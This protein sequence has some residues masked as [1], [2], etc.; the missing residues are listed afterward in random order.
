[1]RSTAMASVTALL[2]IATAAHASLVPYT[3]KSAW[4]DA[5]SNSTYIGFTEYSTGT[6]ITSQYSPVGVTFSDGD[7]TIAAFS[8]GLYPNDGKGLLGSFG[9]FGLD[10]PITVDFDA[11][12]TAVAVEYPG[13]VW[14]TLY[15]QGQVVGQS[16][17]FLNGFTGPFAGV[18]SSVPFDRVVLDNDST[19]GID[20]LYFGSAVPSP[21]AV[22]LVAAAGLFGGRRRRVWVAGGFT[23]EI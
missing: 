17:T 8:F 10:R 5:A 16:G 1:M 4:L 6:P 23:A 19:I 21:G 11:P 7:D 2:G 22:A 20:S 12:R 9:Q 13:V 18:V 15:Y 14:F 3:N